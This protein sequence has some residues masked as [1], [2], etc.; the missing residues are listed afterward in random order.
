MSI[1]ISIWIPILQHIS[2]TCQMR[3]ALVLVLAFGS[4][5]PPLDAALNYT[6]IESHPLL[7]ISISF[8]IVAVLLPVVLVLL[9]LLVPHRHHLHSISISKGNCNPL[10]FPPPEL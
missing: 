3:N 4:P 7:I 5:F 9:V 6:F 8:S 10:S 1:P 2:N